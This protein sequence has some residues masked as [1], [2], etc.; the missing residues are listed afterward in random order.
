L[1]LAMERS[2]SNAL[3]I[4][5]ELRRL[6][7]QVWDDELEPLRELIGGA[8][9]NHGVVSAEAER[10]AYGQNLRPL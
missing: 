1:R 8:E 5:A 3:R 6:L 9:G 10:V 7:G 2:G 4:Q